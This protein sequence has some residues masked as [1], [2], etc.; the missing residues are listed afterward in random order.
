MR[1]QTRLLSVSL[2]LALSLVLSAYADADDKAETINPIGRWPKYAVGQPSR[3][4]IWHNE[5][6]WHVRTTSLDKH[7]AVFT[8]TVKVSGGNLVDISGFGVLEKGKS[9]RGR[10][11]DWGTWNK[12][13]TQLN[14]RFI[15]VGKEDGFDFTVSPEATAVQFTLAIDGNAL[16]KQIFIG[17]EGQNPPATTFELPAHPG[18]KK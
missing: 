16:R 1:T 4:V 6:G 13:K 11:V 5:N 10:A 8:G 2:T 14:F 12:E 9:G 3:I 7:R 18:T 17:R 15:T